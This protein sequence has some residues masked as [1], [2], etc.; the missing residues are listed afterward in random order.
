M[1][2]PVILLKLPMCAPVC[3]DTV[4]TSVNLVRGS[5]VKDCS[6]FPEDVLGENLYC[7]NQSEDFGET[8]V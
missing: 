6:A 8:Y 4:E 2:A 7:L 3:Q 1:G 5:R